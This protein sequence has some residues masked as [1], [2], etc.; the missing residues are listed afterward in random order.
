[1]KKENAQSGEGPPLSIHSSMFSCHKR[2]ILHLV[3]GTEEV[4][5]HSQR[6]GKQLFFNLL[7]SVIDSPFLWLLT[8]KKKKK[9]FLLEFQEAVMLLNIITHSVYS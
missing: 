6:A 2:R 8:V 4:R 5:G 1:M 3:L 9:G 7:H